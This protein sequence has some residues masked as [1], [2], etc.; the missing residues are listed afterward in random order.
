MRRRIYRY[1]KDI[2]GIDANVREEKDPAVLTALDEELTDIDR[3]L[4]DLSLPL[5]YSEYSYTA[6]LHIDLV[7]KRIGD[8]LALAEEAAA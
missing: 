4:A 8:R 6:R 5:P 7:R 3:K 1:Y 2:K